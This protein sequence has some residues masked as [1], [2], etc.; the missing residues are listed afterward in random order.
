MYTYFSHI[1]DETAFEVDAT[2][3]AP[4]TRPSVYDENGN[5]RED[6]GERLER[7]LLMEDSP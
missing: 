6:D 7:K 2:P 4:L 3:S 1:Q 5:P